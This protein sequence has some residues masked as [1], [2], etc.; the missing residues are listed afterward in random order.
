M[1]ELPYAGR[2][3]SLL[4]QHGKEALLRAPLESALGCTLVHTDAFDTDQLGSFTG[5]IARPGSQLDAARLKARTGMTLTGARIGLASEGAFGPD[6]FSGFMPWDTELLLWIDDERG[7]E[8]WGQAQGP[9][10]SL[11]QVAHSWPELQALVQ[12]ARFPSHRLCL[13]PDHAQHARVHKG[14]ADE[15]ALREAFEACRAE[16]A[17]GLVFVENDLRAHANP[18]RQ[19]LIVQAC[20]DLLAKLRSACP[21]C[22]LPGFALRS[23]Q[24]G[25][26]CRQCGLPTRLPVAETWGCAHCQ[27]E[28]LRPLDTSALAD[29]S[30]CDRCNP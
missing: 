4:T 7:I 6:P 26:A 10:Q 24:P 13:R 12:Q 18:T 20:E 17:E 2:R 8:V 27:F 5:E 29:P 23:R 25:L 14:L 3:V 28:Q 1:S 11:A 19:A 16:S 30:R 21:G 22:A 15:A 9:A